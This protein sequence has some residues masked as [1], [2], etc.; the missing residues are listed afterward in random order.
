MAIVKVQRV[1]LVEERPNPSSDFFV[2]PLLKQQQ[3]QVQRLSFTQ[4]PA[5]HELAGCCLIF[6][7]YIPP[8]W[9]QWI[10]QHHS[11][12]AQLVLFIDD[13]ILDPASSAGMPW[14]YR[15]KLWRLSY[16][17]VPWLRRLQGEL[18]VANQYLAQKYQQWQPQQLCA[19]PCLPLLA[20]PPVTLFYHGS[21]S[22][23]AE[24]RWLLPV[25]KAA[26]QRMPELNFEIIA[27]KKIA[28]LYRGMAR[29]QV[30][31]PMSWPSYQA[32][33]QRQRYHIGLAPLLPLPFNLARSV[34]K[35]F[36]ITA[37]G[38][39]GIY[40]DSAIYQAVRD[41]QSGIVLPM[42]PQ[43]WLDEIVSLAADSNKQ[44][45]L[46]QQAQQQLASWQFGDDCAR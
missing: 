44:Q 27:D 40:A 8:Q 17:A 24:A 37:A 12:L 42:D 36:D 30:L 39:V 5:A 10:T 20:K 13:D 19:I 15:L 25:V 4:L 45:Q 34:T 28:A 9:R 23:Q 26:L 14:R 35:F 21:S 6:V 33:L 32:L 29:V 11:T 2:L 46:L 22:H 41:K 16:R 7:R 31:Y 3:C 38:A 18:W 43:R 1:I